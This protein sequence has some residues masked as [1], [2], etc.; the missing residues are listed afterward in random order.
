MHR[1]CARLT[2]ALVAIRALQFIE[3]ASSAE[4]TLIPVVAEVLQQDLL[5][6]PE[7][8]TPDLHSL[9]GIPVTLKVD[10]YF[11]IAH[12]QEHQ[13]GFGNLVFNVDLFRLTQNALLPEWQPDVSTVDINGEALGGVVPKWDDNADIG[14]SAFDLRSVFVG[15]FPR[16][17][18]DPAVDPRYRIGQDGPVYAGSTYVDWDGA[19]PAMLRPEYRHR[20]SHDS[21][22]TFDENKMLDTDDRP[23]SYGEIQLGV[24]AE[25][26]NMRVLDWDQALRDD[27]LRNEEHLRLKNIDVDV[28]FTGD[29]M[30]SSGDAGDRPHIH[31]VPSGSLGDYGLRVPVDFTDASQSLTTVLDFSRVVTDV[32]FGLHNLNLFEGSEEHGPFADQLTVRGFLGDVEVAPDITNLGGVLIEGNVLT[33]TQPS[34]S[35]G[36]LVLF[37]QPIDRIELSFSNAPGILLDP[38]QQG[39]GITDVNFTINNPEPGSIVLAAI[40]CGLLLACRL[41]RHRP[42]APR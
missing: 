22:S 42:R 18:R 21:F 9:H 24:P 39:Y 34:G 1:H 33:G 28:S 19:R 7:G 25:H 11:E 27:A 35:L 13:L 38:G 32:E 17:F 8:T 5:P 29:L 6:F 14:P 10:Y 26:Q 31:I 16:D 37:A 23:A 41:C 3:P 20:F 40:G 30:F 12:L 2:I 15:L 36:A 4:L